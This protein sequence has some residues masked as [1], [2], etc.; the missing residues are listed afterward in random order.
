MDLRQQC[1]RGDE[2]AG[3]SRHPLPLLPHPV[4]DAQAKHQEWQDSR[5]VRD[6]KGPCSK[7]PL[8]ARSARYAF[9]KGD[10]QRFSDAWRANLAKISSFW[11]HSGDMLPGRGAFPVRGR[12]WDTWSAKLA[13]DCRP[14]THQDE[15]LPSPSARK[16]TV[17]SRSWGGTAQTKHLPIQHHALTRPRNRENLLVPSAEKRRRKHARVLW[18]T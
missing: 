13:T 11:I 4:R 14:G 9:P 6:S 7:R 1:G 10:L 5:A 8:L 3:A 18:R 15:I 2:A 16:R 12:F 17:A